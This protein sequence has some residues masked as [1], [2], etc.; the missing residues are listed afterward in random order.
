MK[1][2]VREIVIV[3]AV[4]GTIALACF[5][6]KRRTLVRKEVGTEGLVISGTERISPFSE[7]YRTAL[8]L[9]SRGE[10]SEAEA[11][12]NELAKKEPGVADPYIGLG[13][14]YLHRQDF[15]GAQQSYEK[16]LEIDPKSVNAFIGLGSMYIGLSN[17]TNAVEKYKAALALDEECPDAHWGLV[18]AY[19]RLDDMTQARKHLDRF[20]QLAPDSRYIGHLE[21]LVNDSTPQTSTPAGATGDTGSG[22]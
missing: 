11:I 15:A 20:K 14:C 10:V 4:I 1:T 22:K 9:L 6:T 17:Y 13:A 2:P 21:S 5:L 16:A 18:S 12:Y 19:V 8:N 7:E 3:L